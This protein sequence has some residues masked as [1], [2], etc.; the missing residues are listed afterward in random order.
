MDQV[1]AVVVYK[2]PLNLGLLWRYHELKRQVK[3]ERFKFQKLRN[4]VLDVCNLYFSEFEDLQRRVKDLRRDIRLAT[5]GTPLTIAQSSA[6]DNA[7]YYHGTEQLF[8]TNQ[9]LLKD[10]YRKLM[11]LTHPDK[12]PGR[13]HLFDAVNVAYDLQDLTYLIELYL[14]L[15]DEPNLHWRQAQGIAYQQQ[16]LERPNVSTK[17]LRNAPEFGIMRA[18]VVK[19][20]DAAKRLAE[21]RLLDLVISLNNE[22][23]YILHPTHFQSEN[24]HGSSEEGSQE[25]GN[26]NRGQEGT[27]EAG[28]GRQDVNNQ[29]T[30]HA[31]KAYPG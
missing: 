25:G 18:H 1:T 11:K 16:E 22:L 3:V 23:M 20:T 12:V 7:Y 27:P 31:G 28:E 13:R 30:Y 9:L 26:Q 17:R 24:D 10:A 19:K 5:R 2:E 14:I 4:Q 6:T 15:N 21:L 8:N 29:G